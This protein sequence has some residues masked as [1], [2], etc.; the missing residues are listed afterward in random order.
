[1][2]HAKERT[3]K[4][5]MVPAAMLGFL[6]LLVTFSGLNFFYEKRHSDGWI[7]V[8]HLALLA[9]KFERINQTCGILS[10]DY[11]KNPINFLNVETF[12]GSEV[13]PINLVHPEK[14][15][16]YLANNPIIQNIEY[17]VVRTNQGHFIT[18]GMGVRLPNGMVIGQDILLDADADIATLV[19]D[20]DGLS[21]S[22]KP[23]A[24]PISVRG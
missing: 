24:V 5:C 20:P 14:W 7:M 11:Q 21:F 3:F 8:D 13:G 22:A 2:K 19:A 18:P 12:R 23:L 15:Q 4:E 1:M 16:G 17:M 6:L 10:F 9:K